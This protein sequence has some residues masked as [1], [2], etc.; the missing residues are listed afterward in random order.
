MVF[1]R[2]AGVAG[3]LVVLVLSMV[4]ISA[5]CAS[6]ETGGNGEFNQPIIDG[7][8]DS[9][10]YASSKSLDSG[11][12]LYWSSDS[13]HI[14]IAIEADTTGWIAVGFQP[15]DENKKKDTDIIIGYVSG[16]RASVFDMFSQ[17]PDGPHPLD[18]DLGGSN[19]IIEFSGS[20]AEGVTII[21]FKRKLNTG[22]AYD[23][24]LSKG[25]QRLIWAYSDVDGLYNEHS[26]GKWGYGSIDI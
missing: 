17:N 26:G 21:E 25:N 20:E 14:Y 11:Y 10:E 6:D 2:K 13:E 23:N 1:K 15:D 19:D 18:I 7:V 24:A 3:L 16:G 4:V 9:E 22:D 8:I 5:S 12:M